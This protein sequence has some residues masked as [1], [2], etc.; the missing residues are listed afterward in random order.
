MKKVK[1]LKK[2][3]KV[4]F[5]FIFFPEL[6]IPVKKKQVENTKNP[7]VEIKLFPWLKAKNR[8]T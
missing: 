2:I 5:L 3:L 8:I 6:L 1:S 4:I 7:K